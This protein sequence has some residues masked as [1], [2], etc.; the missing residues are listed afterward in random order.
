MVEI[1]K[2][3][4]AASSAHT[5]FGVA[6]STGVQKLY[7]WKHKHNI[8]I[9]KQLMKQLAKVFIFWTLYNFTVTG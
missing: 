1:I 3:K 9:L 5:S 2:L 8:L 7:T 4:G 6:V